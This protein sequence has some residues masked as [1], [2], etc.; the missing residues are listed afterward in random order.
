MTAF[1]N[2]LLTI[3]KKE[4]TTKPTFKGRKYSEYNSVIKNYMEAIN[5]RGY[6]SIKLCHLMRDF[7]YKKRGPQNILKINKV[8]STHKLFCDPPINMK[9]NWKE[10]LRIYEFPVQR[11]GDIFPNEKDL[12]KYMFDKHLFNTIGV[13]HTEREKSLPGTA[14][15]FDFYGVF[16]KTHI[17]IEVKLKDGNKSAVEQLLR[18]GGFLNKKFPGESIRKILITGVSDFWTAYAI[19]GMLEDGR[20]EIE[21]Y[22]YKYNKS[23]DTISLIPMKY[24]S[25][26]NYFT[27]HNPKLSSIN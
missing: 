20:G 5:E 11:F 19:H 13:P 23:E 6:K 26:S 25:Y 8:L 3:F 2:K 17:I 1:F 27:P 15:I 24:E 4:S 21:W 22:I 16:A 12:Q 9:T 10:N 14:D 7:Q 18:Y